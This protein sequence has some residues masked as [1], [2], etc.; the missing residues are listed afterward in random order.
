[1]KN[2]FKLYLNI[3]F[4]LISFVGYSQKEEIVGLESNPILTSF[5]KSQNKNN[6]KINLKSTQS[7]SLPFFDDFSKGTL[8]PDYSNWSDSSAFI[9]SYIGKYPITIGVAT[10]DALDKYGNIHQDFGNRIFIADTLTSQPIRLDSITSTLH[11]ISISDSLYLSFF[12]PPQ[13]WASPSS[14]DD[15]LVLEFYNPT[16][17]L[18]HHIWATPGMSYS[19]FHAINDTSFKIVMIPIKDS[20]FLRNDFKFRFKNYVSILNSSQPSWASNSNQWNIDY[21]YLNVNRSKTDT[22]FNDVAF[23]TYPGSLLT[24]YYSVPWTHYLANST[25]QLISNV[26]VKIRNLNSTITNNVK[27]DFSISD[28]Y[29]VG[30]AFNQT[31]GNININPGTESLYSTSINGFSFQSAYSSNYAA[32]MVS[33]MIDSL[34]YSIR[35]NDTVRSYQIFDNYYAY[36]DGVP[37]AGYGLSGNG[38]NQG[39]VAYKFNLLKGDTLRGVNIF[40]NRTLSGASQKPF[41]LSVW[42]SITPGTSNETSIY[43]SSMLLQPLY[44]GLNDYHLYMLESPIYCSGTIY[45]GWIQT[46]ED[47]LNVGLDLTNNYGWSNANNQNENLLKYLN[48][49]WSYSTIVNGA[50]MIRPVFSSSSL[51]GIN[52]ISSENNIN[53][54]PN[55]ASDFINLKLNSKNSNSKILIYD[56][57]GKEIKSINIPDNSNNF[58]INTTDLKEGVYF[59]KLYYSDKIEN[60]KFVI[61]K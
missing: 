2:R 17:T 3:C 19:S 9:N 32:F 41:Y 43:T 36:D 57:L 38:S 7:L 28:Y 15:S 4:L 11:K 22:S 48:G 37:E 58:K 33:A 35:S 27:R 46:T 10:L 8:F 29:G 50:L 18:W 25:G 56:L 20:T 52:E 30:T 49:S 42:S 55:P 24:N 26:N 53:V 39:K 59:G 60:F 51:T 21:V 14:S 12:Y 16:D 6:N 13:G 61:K 47:N 1:M 44:D 40:F 54:F 31:G 45:V 5:L 34:A 23:T